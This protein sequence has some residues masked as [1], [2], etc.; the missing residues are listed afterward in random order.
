MSQWDKI[1]ISWKSARFSVAI[2]KIWYCLLQSDTCGWN[3]NPSWSWGETLSLSSPSCDSILI[4]FMKQ[5]LDCLA[6]FH[7]TFSLFGASVAKRWINSKMCG[8][9]KCSLSWR[10][11]KSDPLPGN[12]PWPSTTKFSLLKSIFFSFIVLP[13]WFIYLLVCSLSSNNPNVTD[14]WGF[15]TNRLSWVVIS[16]EKWTCSK[17]GKGDGNCCHRVSREISLPR[18]SLSIGH[19]TPGFLSWVLAL[20]YAW[21]T[22]R[23]FWIGNAGRQ[24][25]SHIECWCCCP[26]KDEVDGDGQRPVFSSF[27]SRG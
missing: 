2:R 21:R 8:G 24:P 18:R 19:E 7:T 27:D 5:L 16:V 17:W 3:E 1:E 26:E 22:I 20:W 9:D 15:P 25:L 4:Q 12:G 11:I 13:Y 10:G 14:P 23:D 6:G